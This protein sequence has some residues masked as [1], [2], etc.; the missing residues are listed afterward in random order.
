MKPQRHQNDSAM[1]MPVGLLAT[2]L[3]TLGVGCASVPMASTQEDLWTKQNLRAPPGRSLIVLYR[4][5]SFGAAV[6]MPVMLDGRVAG[7]TAARVYFVWEVSPGTHQLASLTENTARLSLQA[8][9]GWTYFVWQEVKMGTWQ[10]GSALHLV[11]EQTGRQAVAECKL[12]RSQIAPP[13][14]SAA[15]VSVAR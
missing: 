7:Q 1:R 4:N 6:K 13:P 8:D 2:L 12:A 15:P 14:S 3:L 11:D 10:A 5:E 9:P